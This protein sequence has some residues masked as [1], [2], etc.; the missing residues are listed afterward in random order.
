M[1]QNDKVRERADCLCLSGD[2]NCRKSS[3]KIFNPPGTLWGCVWL[4][5]YCIAKIENN[6]KEVSI[7]TLQRFIEL[8][9]GEHLYLSIKL[10]LDDLWWVNVMGE[11]QK[12][13]S[14]G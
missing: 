10:V 6:S 9:L 4:T 1:E 8:G 13:P 14:K 5:K 11:Y 2:I 7:S 3:S 12:Y